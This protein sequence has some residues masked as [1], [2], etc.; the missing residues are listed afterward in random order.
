MMT[1]PDP[2]T[3]TELNGLGLRTPRTVADFADDN[4]IKI[5][6]LA[7]GM[8]VVAVPLDDAPTHNP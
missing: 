2:E 6:R 7:S 3:E 4:R 1:W 8:E 5:V